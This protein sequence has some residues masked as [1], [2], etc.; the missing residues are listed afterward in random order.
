L[1]RSGHHAVA[2]QNAALWRVL[3]QAGLL[4]KMERQAVE[5]RHE[6]RATAGPHQHWHI[7]VS[8]INLAGTLHYLCSVLDAYS[9]LIVYWDLRESKAEADIEII[10]KAAKEK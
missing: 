9:R 4:S 7:D 2:I 10:L 8:Y 3:G 6:L 1:P 5:E